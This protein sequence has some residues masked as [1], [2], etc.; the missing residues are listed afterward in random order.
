MP[1]E[2]K[3]VRAANHVLEILVWCPDQALQCPTKA[4]GLAIIF[5]KTLAAVRTDPLPYGRYVN[6]NS[7]KAFVMLVVQLAT[8]VRS[9]EQ[10]TS[11]FWK[12]FPRPP[13]SKSTVTWLASSGIT[14]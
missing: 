5:Q 1:R 12:S 9:Q 14:S 11:A 8:G 2:D 13:S 6:F 4:V 10:T 3:K 7:L